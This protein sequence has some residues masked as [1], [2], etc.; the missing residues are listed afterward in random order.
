LARVDQK[1]YTDKRAGKARP[2]DQP[3]LR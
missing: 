2:E 1:L 3:V